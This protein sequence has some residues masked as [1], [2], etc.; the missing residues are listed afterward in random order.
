MAIDLTAEQIVTDLLSKNEVLTPDKNTSIPF[1]K[2]LNLGEYLT[3][4]PKESI[5][6]PIK[7]Y[8]AHNTRYTFIKGKWIL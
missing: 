1:D 6:E 4:L 2:R 7:E 8:S 3:N 5:E